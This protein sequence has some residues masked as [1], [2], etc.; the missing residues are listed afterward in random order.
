M[1]T[2]VERSLGQRIIEAAAV[3]PRYGGVTGW[4]A[5]RW[6]GGYWFDGLATGGSD[7][8][9]VVLAT[10]DS[11]V[12][13]RPGIEIS[14]EGLPPDEL[15]TVDSLRVTTVARSLLFEMRYAGSDREAVQ[16]FDMAAYSDLISAEEMMAYAAAHT[17]WT[18]IPQ[19]RRALGLVDE[20][21]WSPAET[22]M[23]LIWV[24]DA[25]LPPPLCNVPIFDRA[26]NHIG[27]P[28][29]LDLEAGLVGEYDG[30]LHLAGE[31]RR[32]DRRREE[33][34]RS[35]GLEC[36]TMMSGDGDR[37]QVAERLLDARKR[38]RFEAESRRLW[39]VQP[40][41][42]WIPTR[43]VSERRA[44]DAVQR[45]RLLGLRLRAG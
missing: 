25:E 7:V 22:R 8:R 32:R 38:A 29:L 33:A 2:S 45:D 43:T 23:R 34:F 6:Q 3:L 28:D 9:A 42:W 27:T 39:T 17:A 20:N 1:P 4:A 24:L 14:E 30:A 31:Q 10:A 5:L 18:G 21:S 11:S 40:P 35:A 19:A 36:V 12:R 26:G 16:A 41:A 37:W 15:A 44:L 13:A